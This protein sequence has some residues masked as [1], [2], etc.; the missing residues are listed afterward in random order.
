LG[1]EDQATTTHHPPPH[2]H[3]PNPHVPLNPSPMGS[4]A[5]PTPK[6]GTRAH[7]TSNPPQQGPKR[8]AY[9]ERRTTLY[10]GRAHP[11]EPKN[12]AW[13]GYTPVVLNESIT[14]GGRGDPRV[15]TSD[16]ARMHRLDPWS[17]S[18]GVRGG[19]R[20]WSLAGPGERRESI[21]VSPLP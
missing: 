17:P 12:Q 15:A 4:T 6:S 3:P 10:W 1:Q 19:G 20:G 5:K 9:H 16:Q 8:V 18:S 2:T 21:S 14:A 11:R 13:K 7:P